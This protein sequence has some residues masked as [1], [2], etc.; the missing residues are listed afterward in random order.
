MFKLSGLMFNATPL[1]AVVPIN[2]FELLFIYQN[3]LLHVIFFECFYF[4]IILFLN[5]SF[6]FVIVRVNH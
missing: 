5:L 4:K 3:D 2:L 6:L 1:I